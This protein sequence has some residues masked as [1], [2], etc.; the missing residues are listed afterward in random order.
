MKYRISAFATLLILLITT[1]WSISS[2]HKASAEETPTATPIKTVTLTPESFQP[3]ERFSG[4]LQGDNQTDIR[5]NISGTVTSIQKNPGETAQQGE[6]IAVLTEESIASA[7]ASATH[8][9]SATKETFETIKRYYN[10]K[11]NEA[12]ATLKKTKESKRSGDATTKDIDVAEE[13]VASAKRLRD[14]ELSQAEAAIIATQGSELI[15]QSSAHNL[16]IR[17]PF[18]GTI[19][20]RNITLGSRVFPGDI[21][22]VFASTKNYELPISVP[23]SIARHVSVG[24]PLNLLTE[25]SEAPLSGIIDSYA[26][27]S[28][29]KTGETLVRIRIQK[30]NNDAIP[31][32]GSFVTAE[33]PLQ[34][35][36]SS[37][38]IPTSALVFRYGDPIVFI[39]EEGH[40]KIRN[41]ELGQSAGD[42]REILSGIQTGDTLITAGMHLLREGDAVSIS[43]ETN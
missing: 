13:A 29:D 3:T 27:A 32:I 23:V 4:F 14:A 20:R 22:F 35:K 37:I 40:A 34:E 25:E 2:N 43:S 7:N 18:S 19:L 30:N 28:D 41:V 9:V 16:V 39:V 17:A 8:S 31:P 11:I 21:L 33:F 15:A 26:P 5:T 36:T 10:Q 38:V 42:H 12:E 1:L 6:V 24:T